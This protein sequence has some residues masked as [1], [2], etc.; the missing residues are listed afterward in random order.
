MWILTGFE[1]FGNYRLNPSWES[2][3][4]IDEGEKIRVPVAYDDSVHIA[5][6]IIGRRPEIVLATG[7]SPSSRDLKIETLGINIMYANIPD[8]KGIIKKGE[9]IIKDGEN[10]YFTNVPFIGLAEHLQ[11]SGYKAHVSFSAGTYVCN[12][13]YYALL[14]YNTKTEKKAKI[15]F[16][17]IPPTDILQKAETKQV[18]KIDEITIALKYSLEFISRLSSL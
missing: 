11:K 15:V 1:P 18:M 7:L 8:N 3:K 10:C 5:R 14:H 4:R 16:I 13:F 12:T 2:V 9:Q 17:H 6:E